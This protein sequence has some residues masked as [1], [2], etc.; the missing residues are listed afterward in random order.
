MWLDA[1]IERREWLTL[2]HSCWR[3]IS[4]RPLFADI[5]SMTNHS[6]DVDYAHHSLT[7]YRGRYQRRELTGQTN[8]QRER[9]KMSVR[10]IWGVEVT[11][12]CC[13]IVVDLL[14][15]I[16][17]IG[18]DSGNLMFTIQFLIRDDDLIEECLTTAMKWRSQISL[19]AWTFNAPKDAIRPIANKGTQF[20][21]V[22][23][24]KGLRIIRKEEIQQIGQCKCKAPVT[25]RDSV[26]PY[27]LTFSSSFAKSEC[28]SM[29][30]DCG[31]DGW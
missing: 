19:F 8:E 21:V 12:C 3:N 9:E 28:N 16:D 25:D 31:I 1:M 13:R 5:P 6:S 11:S 7:S 27:H 18:D 26:L 20:V 30:S 10:T 23:D 14:L 24:L 17:R 29:S 15:M 2:C 22:N 4:E